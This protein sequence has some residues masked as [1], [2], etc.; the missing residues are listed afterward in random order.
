MMKSKEKRVNDI[1]RTTVSRKYDICGE[2]TTIKMENLCSGVIDGERIIL[3]NEYV[4]SMARG[5]VDTIKRYHTKYITIPCEIIV[6]SD[7]PCDAPEEGTLPDNNITENI[8]L[9]NIDDNYKSF[10]KHLDL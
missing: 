7:S 4:D 1:E 3:D 2:T 8:P 10:F 6:K 5:I 9:K